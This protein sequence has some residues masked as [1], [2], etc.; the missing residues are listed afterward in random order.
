M[1]EQS[2]HPL[3]MKAQ[4]KCILKVRRNSVKFAFVCPK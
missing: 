3:E 2:S 4:Q 1:Y